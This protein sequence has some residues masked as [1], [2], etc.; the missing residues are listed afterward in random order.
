MRSDRLMG[1]SPKSD[2]PIRSVHAIRSTN[3]DQ[4]KIRISHWNQSDENYWEPRFEH[5]WENWVV[6]LSWVIGL[7]ICSLLKLVNIY[8]GLY[9]FPLNLY[10]PIPCV[11][12][13]KRIGYIA[14]FCFIYP[15]PTPLSYFIFSSLFFLKSFHN[16]LKKHLPPPGLT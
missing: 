7:L 13:Y 14:I 8:T 5:R 12:L 9:N 1:I 4:S 3:G 10:F 15:I 16:A 6:G 2:R 11:N